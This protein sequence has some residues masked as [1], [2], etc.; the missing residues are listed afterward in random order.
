M[1]KVCIQ[2]TLTL[3]PPPPPPP[4][5]QN[6]AGPAAGPRKKKNI[7]QH[8][9]NRCLNK[10]Y[11]YLSKFKCYMFV[12]FFAIICHKKD[13][14]LLITHIVFIYKIR[15]CGRTCQIYKHIANDIQQNVTK[16][17]NL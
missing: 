8:I 14:V 7:T 4:P 1:Q 10:L 17:T 16:Y 6:Q 13:I 9:I 15:G 2:A 12:M 3:P 5:M 11:N